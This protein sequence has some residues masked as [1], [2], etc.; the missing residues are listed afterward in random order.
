MLKRISALDMLLT[1]TVTRDRKKQNK[2]FD[3]KPHICPGGSGMQTGRHA[4]YVMLFYA[5]DGWVGGWI[6]IYRSFH[7]PTGLCVYFSFLFVS[8]CCVCKYS[9]TILLVCLV[10]L[11]LFWS[12]LYLSYLT[13]LSDCLFQLSHRLSGLPALSIYPSIHPSQC[14]SNLI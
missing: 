5:I 9:W 13:I 14:E 7:L 3:F 12:M 2:P 6:S 11:S 4:C 8:K 10:L 1:S